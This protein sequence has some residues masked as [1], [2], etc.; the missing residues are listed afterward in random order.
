MASWFWVGF[1]VAGM[2]CTVSILRIESIRDSA[3]FATL[4]RNPIF[5]IVLVLFI[6]CW[7]I[8]HLV[9][10]WWIARSIA[11]LASVKVVG[12]L[13]TGNYGVPCQYHWGHDCEHS[14]KFTDDMTEWHRSDEIYYRSIGDFDRANYYRELADAAERGNFVSYYG[15]FEHD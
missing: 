3:T 2:G 6:V 12:C 7:P 4:S 10:N 1:W 5:K 15:F 9:M 11:E 8:S 14:F 13:A